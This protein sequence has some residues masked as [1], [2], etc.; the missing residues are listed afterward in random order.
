MPNLFYDLPHVIQDLSFT[1]SDAWNQTLWKLG[2]AYFDRAFRIDKNLVLGDPRQANALTHQ[3]LDSRAATIQDEPEFLLAEIL[4]PF[5]Y[6][7]LKWVWL[8]NHDK[9]F[10]HIWTEGV[11]LNCVGINYFYYIRRVIV[12]FGPDL[13]QNMLMVFPRMR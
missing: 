6:D 2:I 5:L 11:R 3:K 8:F 4:F 9:C 10:N 7:D 13:M 1:G 12:F